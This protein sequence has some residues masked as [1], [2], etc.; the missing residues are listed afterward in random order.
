[1]IFSCADNRNPNSLASRMRRKRVEIFNHLLKNLPSPVRVLDIGGTPDFWLK[2]QAALT[3]KCQITLLNLDAPSVQ[4][5][6]ISIVVGDARKMPQF[7]DHSFDIGFSNSVLEHVGTLYDQLSMAREIQRTC[8]SYFV[9]TPNRYFPI[10][11]HFLIPLWQFSP[12]W[13]RTILLRKFRLGWM[14]QEPNLFR[15]RAEIEQI[16]LLTKRELRWLF[17]EAEIQSEKFG[18]LTKSWMAIYRA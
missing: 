11:P 6:E 5:P 16:R 2:N 13:Y 8:R 12:V 3:T 15:A 4:P 14:P 10:E 7:R 18:P 9:Q 17:P 1:M